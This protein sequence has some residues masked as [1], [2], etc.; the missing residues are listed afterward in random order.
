MR[1]CHARGKFRE[2]LE[3]SVRPGHSQPRLAVRPSIRRFVPVGA[4]FMRR[5]SF[6]SLCLALS[7]C[8]YNT[9][10]NPPFATATNPNF[11]AD[12][13]ENVRRV[14]GEQ[15]EAP[16][17][18]AGTGRHL[19]GP[20]AAIADTAGP[21]DAGPADRAP[22]SGTRLA[23]EPGSTAP[24]PAAAARRTWQLDATPVEPAGD[25]DAAGTDATASNQLDTARTQPG[26]AGPPHPARARRS[27]TGAPAATRP[28]RPPAAVRRSSS[29]MAMAPAR[30]YIRTAGS[31]RSPHRVESPWPMPKHL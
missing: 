16:A 12:A 11:P 18:D 5:I 13:S 1:R 17:A 10:W 4:P 2:V 20:L 28:P 31:R 9:W 23:A 3:R 27:R 19:A 21:R 29:P 6:I 8:G 14:M 30:S 22:A 15:V 7:G 24:Q 25:G 26:G